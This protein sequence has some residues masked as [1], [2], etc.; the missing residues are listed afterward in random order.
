MTTRIRQS[1]GRHLRLLREARGLTQE[2]LAERSELSPDTVRRLEHDSFSPGLD[3]LIKLG[4]GLDLQMST[5][6][7]GFELNERDSQR[8]LLDL[9]GSQDPRARRIGIRVLRSLFAQVDAMAKAHDEG[10][11]K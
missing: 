7:H 10:G 6:F 3:T 9:M 5:L 2:A 1:F 8:E 4:G 11:E